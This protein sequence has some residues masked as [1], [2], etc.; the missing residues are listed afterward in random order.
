MSC[1]IS[2]LGSTL[3]YVMETMPQ[4]YSVVYKLSTGSMTE[5]L[6]LTT[7]LANEQQSSAVQSELAIHSRVLHVMVRDAC[8][9]MVCR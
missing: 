3:K 2:L 5:D 1:P 4:S 9:T 7:G 8:S 6:Q